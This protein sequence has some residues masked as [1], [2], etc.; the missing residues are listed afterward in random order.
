MHTD[1]GLIYINTWKQDTA[2]DSEPAGF[3]D[4]T[5]IKEGKELKWEMPLSN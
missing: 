3:P 1:G 2:S 5:R 4:K